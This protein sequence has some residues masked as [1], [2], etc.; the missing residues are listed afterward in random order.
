MVASFAVGEDMVVCFSLL[1]LLFLLSNKNLVI[2]PEHSNYMDVDN[3][4]ITKL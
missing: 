3:P 1:F 4:V 2:T